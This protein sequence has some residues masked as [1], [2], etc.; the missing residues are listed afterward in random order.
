VT[1]RITALVLAGSRAGRQDP[2]ALAGG[3]THKALVSI[4]GK[5]M[6]W[7]VLRTLRACPQIGTIV[8][9]AQNAAA[10]LEGLDG[11]EGVA[12]REGES[13]P[14]RSVGAM[15]AEFGTPLLVTT[16]DHPL[17]TPAMVAHFLAA[18][19]VDIDVIAAIAGAPLVQAAFP[20]TKRTWLRFRGGAYSGCNLFLL[21]A[22]AASGAI[23]F[24]ERLEQDRKRPLALARM[25]GLG[26][27]ILYA[28]R[29]ATLDGML[30]RLGRLTGARL[31]VVELPFA[32][33]AVDVDKPEDLVLVETIL[34]QRRAA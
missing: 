33:A 21:A 32:E 16:A 23:K 2:V 5:P 9:C 26:S 4:A 28:A 8:V 14:S 13:G 34:A 19:R 30:R 7:H 17:L 1:E 6:L 29:Q 10:L 27:L 3:T 24:W 15:M 20:Y 11:A 31:A 22:P 25:L 18:P 12:A